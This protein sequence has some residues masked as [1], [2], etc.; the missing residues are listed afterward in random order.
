[1]N[2]LSPRYLSIFITV[3]LGIKNSN[4]DLDSTCPNCNC[5]VSSKQSKKSATLP[6]GINSRL[7]KDIPRS[8]LNYKLF[9]LGQ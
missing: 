2:S 6:H 1:M 7:R 3:V 4:S 5:C 9:M 8:H